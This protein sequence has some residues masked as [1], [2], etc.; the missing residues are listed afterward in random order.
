MKAVGWWD[1]L[2]VWVMREQ[3]A[4]C[5][6]KVEQGG[7]QRQTEKYAVGVWWEAARG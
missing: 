6:F 1:G 2:S 5:H 3:S 7:R 4:S